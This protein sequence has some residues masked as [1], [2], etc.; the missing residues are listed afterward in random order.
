[1]SEAKQRRR[2]WYIV[3]GILVA[4]FLV[5]G[6]SSFKKNLTPYVGFDEAMRATSRVQVVGK[7]V[8]GSSSYIQATNKL[9]FLLVDDKGITMQVLYDGPKPGNFEEA[10]QVVAVGSYGGGAFNAEQLLV[11]CP[12]K[13]QGVAEDVSK[14]S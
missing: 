5:Y 4:A 10:T 7:L 8:Q 3:G 14:H 6:G 12:S 11:K 2:L 1:M 9:G 13:Y